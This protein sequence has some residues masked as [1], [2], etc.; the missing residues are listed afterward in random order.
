MK[1]KVLISIFQAS[2]I[3]LC[4]IGIYNFVINDKQ[5]SGSG[6]IK[7]TDS[8][9]I[10][11]Y[12]EESPKRVAITNTYAATVMRMLDISEEVIVGVSGDFDDEKLWPELSDKPMIQHSAHSEIDFEAILDTRPD[13]YIVFANNGMVDTKGIREKLEPVGIKVIALDFYKY[14]SLRYEINVLATLFDKEDQMAG[15][16]DEFDEIE[17]MVA[18][19]FANLNSSDRPK[20]VME[21][22]AS[23]TRDPVVLTGTSQWTDLIYRAGG[24]NVFDDLPGHTTHVDMEAILDVNPDVLMF[25]GITFDIGYDRYDEDGTTCETHMQHIEGRSGFENLNAIIDDR[26]LVLSGEFAGPMMIHGLPTL[27]K[28]LH[29]ELFLDVDAESYLDDYF[30]TYHGVERVGK[31]VCTS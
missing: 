10:E 15:L 28:Y 21:H 27:A 1:S 3:V 2:I 7:I 25:D 29:P 4:S 31:F 26:M 8:N 16:F 22:H 9:N 13:I 17:T 23:L 14:D 18:S 30:T 19:K 20:I 6:E 12:F 5:D 24:I 11:H